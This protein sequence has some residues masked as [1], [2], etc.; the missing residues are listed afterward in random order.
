MVF[1]DNRKSNL[2]RLIAQNDCY[3]IEPTMVLLAMLAL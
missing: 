2:V 3:S 1:K